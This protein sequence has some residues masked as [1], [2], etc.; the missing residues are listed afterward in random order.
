MENPTDHSFIHPERTISS[1]ETNEYRI[2]KIS[3]NKLSLKE[4]SLA[5]DPLSRIDYYN[6]A[7]FLMHRILLPHKEKFCYLKDLGK[8]S[9]GSTT[10]ANTYF[11]LDELTVA[12]Y[13]LPSKFLVPMSKSPKDTVSLIAH[14][15]NKKLNLLHVPSDVNLQEHKI[16]SEYLDYVKHQIQNRPFFRNKSEKSWFRISKMQ[17]DLMIPNMIY[18]R[19][20]VGYNIDKLHI[21]KQWIGFWIKDKKWLFVLLCFMNS[22]LGSLLREIQGTRTL[23][24]GSLKISLKECQNLLVLDP[25]KFPDPLIKELNNL[26]KQLI[27]EEIPSIGER[28][29]YTKIQREID[30]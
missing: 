18:K 23:G 5:F 27:K 1:R 15:P 29:K 19:S 12:K 13:N 28:T 4:D 22:S 2:S 9:L 26:G 17:P 30:R 20:F 14:I 10:G 6:M 3:S 16:L 8:T 24:L 11:Y 21:D 7:P 25:R